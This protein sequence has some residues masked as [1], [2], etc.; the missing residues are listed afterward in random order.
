MRCS[1]HVID[2]SV[3]A[4]MSQNLFFSSPHY[5]L[6]NRDKY[7]VAF[8]TDSNDYIARKKFHIVPC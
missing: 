6:R 8:L 1:F 3:Q 2:K 4:K 5:S 7:N